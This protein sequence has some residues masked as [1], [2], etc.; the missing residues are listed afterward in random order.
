MN[1]ARARRR[2]LKW[3]RYDDRLMD[4]SAHT[5]ITPGRRKAW[6]Q[7]YEWKGRK[8]DR[9]FLVV[10]HDPVWEPTELPIDAEG[11]TRPGFVCVHPLENGNGLCEGNVFRIEDEVAPHSC[12]VER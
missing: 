3:D 4:L 10:E 6:R 11:N 9:K 12:V 5:A 2:W 7:K 8:W 1:L